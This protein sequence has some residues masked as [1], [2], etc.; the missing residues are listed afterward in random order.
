[1]SS[2]VVHSTKG[3]S[4]NRVLDNIGQALSSGILAYTNA[5]QQQ[6]QQA[7]NAEMQE[8]MKQMLGGAGQ[9]G[10]QQ[11]HTA[12]YA[13]ALQGGMNNGMNTGNMNGLQSILAKF[14]IGV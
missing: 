1:M 3:N 4:T 9:Q 11:P 8:L 14:G 13:Q 5:Q 10:M 2:R 6:Q 7:N 12:E